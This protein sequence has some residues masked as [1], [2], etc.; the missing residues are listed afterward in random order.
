MSKTKAPRPKAEVYQIE[1][2]GHRGIVAVVRA[3]T[4]TQALEEYFVSSNLKQKGYKKGKRV[5]N[6]LQVTGKAEVKI[7]TA[8]R[9]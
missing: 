2:H 5:G 3:S 6:T 8:V 7:L 4:P 1:E 9:V